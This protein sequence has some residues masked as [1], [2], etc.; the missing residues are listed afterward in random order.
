MAKVV[1]IVVAVVAVAMPV[2][3]ITEKETPAAVLGMMTRV[4]TTILGVDNLR[5]GWMVVVSPDKYLMD[6]AI[7]IYRSAWMSFCLDG[8]CR[9][10]FVMDDWRF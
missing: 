10:K 4:L 6:V 9:Y 8:G 3:S 2:A 7:N 5:S 1:I